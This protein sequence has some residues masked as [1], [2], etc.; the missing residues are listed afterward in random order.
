[1]LLIQFQSRQGK[2]VEQTLKTLVAPTKKKPGDIAYVLHRST[3][4]PD[5]L[6]FDEDTFL[7]GWI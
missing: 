6:V 7:N 3:E 5:E 1:M 2:E 4:R